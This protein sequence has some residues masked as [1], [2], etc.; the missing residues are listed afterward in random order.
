MDE[1]LVGGE[2]RVVEAPVGEV[3]VGGVAVPVGGR[4]VEGELHPVPLRLVVAEL[5]HRA[6]AGVGADGDKHA[7][8]EGG[9]GDEEGSGDGR[10]RGLPWEPR[11]GDE[12]IW[13]GSAVFLRLRHWNGLWISELAGSGT[14]LRVGV[15]RVFA[16]KETASLQNAKTLLKIKLE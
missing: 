4:E 2:G 10:H 7:D 6:L 3:V 8:E 15:I 1:A 9:E 16:V 12:R 11:S 5:G 13:G 14:R